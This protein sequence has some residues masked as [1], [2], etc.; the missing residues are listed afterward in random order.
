MNKMLLLIGLMKYQTMNR[1]ERRT[2]GFALV[3]RLQTLKNSPI[4]AEMD[5]KDIPKDVLND[6]IVG[7]CKNSALQKRYNLQKRIFSEIAESEIWMHN[8]RIDLEQKTQRPPKNISLQS[9][10]LKSSPS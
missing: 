5:L 3:K 1:H 4:L 8:A 7:C 9:K 2:K 6:L 10:S